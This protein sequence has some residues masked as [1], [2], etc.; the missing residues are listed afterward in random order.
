MLAAL[1]G[2]L[3]L[4]LAL[5]A[6]EAEHDLLRG[7]SLLVKDGLGLSAKSHLLPVVASLALGKVGS[8]A[9]LVL[10]HLVHL[11]LPALFTLAEGAA[12]F[13]NIDLCRFKKKKRKK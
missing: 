6:L 1:E 11:V 5:L 3:K 7:L 9:S 13:G 12:L 2:N 8:F 4:R 10:R